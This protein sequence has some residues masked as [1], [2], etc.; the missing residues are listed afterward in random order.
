M[1]AKKFTFKTEKPTGRYRSF[2][3]STHLIKLG[4]KVVGTISDSSPYKIHLTVMK[5]DKITDNNPNCE[6]KNITLKRESESLQ[7]AKDWL[8][9]VID[10]ILEAYDL[11]QE[12]Y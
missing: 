1:K 11:H 7:G 6:W 9:S 4:G 5:T 3:P 2:Y 12:E 8:N 10:N